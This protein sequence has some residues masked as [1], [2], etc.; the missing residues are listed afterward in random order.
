MPEYAGTNVTIAYDAEVCTHSGNCVKGLPSVF[1]VNA[2][3]WVQPDQASIDE[4][5]NA[6]RNCPSGALTMR[7]T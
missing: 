7:Q 5:K 3:P 6:I 1:N 2:D 4:V